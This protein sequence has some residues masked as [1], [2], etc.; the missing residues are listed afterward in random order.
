MMNDSSVFITYAHRDVDVSRVVGFYQFIRDYLPRKIEILLDRKALNVGKNIPN[1]VDR[2]KTCP[3]VIILFSPEYKRKVEGSE[4]GVFKEYVIIRKRFGKKNPDLLILP[5]LFEGTAEAS[6]PELFSKELNESLTAFHPR[7]NKVIDRFYLPDEHK[8]EC[9]EVFKS[10]ALAVESKISVRELVSPDDV[11]VLLD[12]FFAKTKVTKSALVDHPEFINHLFVDTLSYRR[13]RR[14]NALFLIGR[15]GSGKSTI[16][17]TLPAL[18][19]AKYK[20]SVCILANHINLVSTIELISMDKLQS[21]FDQINSLADSADSEFVKLKPVEFLFKYAWLG[22]IYICLAEEL[23]RLGG[24]KN[25]LNDAQVPYVDQLNRHSEVF[26]YGQSG[27]I[28]ASRYFSVAA[29]SFFEFWDRE[30]QEALESESLTNVVQHLE[31]NVNEEK[32]LQNFLGEDFLSCIRAIVANCD[33]NKRALVTLDDFDTAFALF[34][35]SVNSAKSGSSDEVKSRS[36]IEDSWIHA[37]MMLVLDLKKVTEPEWKDQLFDKVDF[38][39][40]IPKDSF[41]HVLSRDRDAFLDLE[42]T[43]DLEWTGIYLAEVLLKRLGFIFNEK[44]DEDE[45][46]AEL[47]RILHAY[48]P[49]LPT[50]L[51]FSFNGTRVTI[52]L[53]CYV[54]RHS[55]W[56]PRDVLTHYAALLTAANASPGKKE[57]T[58]EQIRRIIGHKARDISRTEFK[59][60]FGDIFKNLGKIMATFRRTSQL[61]SYNDLH[62]VLLGF[63]FDIGIGVVSEFHEKLRMLYELG[64]IGIQLDDETL[65]DENRATREC[66]YFNEG[67][68]IFSSVVESSIQRC[69]FIIHPIFVEELHIDYKNNDFVLNWDEAYL[70]QNHV[71]REAII[72]PR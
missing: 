9:Q 1:Y 39:I 15:K 50:S 36:E 41:T 47:K 55:F 68:S 61:Q 17:N 51:S 25:A 21:S 12:A 46:F 8:A 27:N 48:V 7:K 33:V 43:A 72:D 53:F 52:D 13:V 66:F 2:L 69:H 28:D 40:T 42:V 32:F 29:V 3:V 64:F 38:C 60:E 44:F 22:V 67:S 62:D 45:P 56:R 11:E 71:E 23:R 59:K 24:I 4:G 49:S 10:L 6:I 35:E 63:D 54:L 26:F 65:S 20:A 14:Q 30:V 34:R 57:L 37:L 5:I 18:E 70:Q 31:A 58:V 19:H 16:S